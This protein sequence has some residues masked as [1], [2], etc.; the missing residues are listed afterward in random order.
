MF[1]VIG[2]KCLFY[3]ENKETTVDCLLKNSLFRN[4]TISKTEKIKI[5]IVRIRY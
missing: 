4:Y 2:S 1:L 3:K 5:I